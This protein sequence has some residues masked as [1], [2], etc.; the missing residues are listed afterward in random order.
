MRRA[1]HRQLEFAFADSPQGGKDARPTDAS[2]GKAYLLHIANPRKANP[3]AATAA[4][5][6]RLLEE[7]ASEPNLARALLHVASNKGAPGVDGKSVDAVLGSAR[8]LLPLL[9]RELL[10]G[11]YRPGDVR[12]VWIRK[13]QGG[14]RGLGIP[15]VMDRWAQQALLQVLEPIFEPG[16]HPSSHGFRPGRGASTAIAEA[17]SYVEQGLTWVVDLDL[18]KFFDRVNHQRL[19]AR[20]EC[21]VKDRRV[22]DLVR[23]MLKANVVMPDGTRVATQVGTPQG[24]PLSPLLSNIVLD[25]LDRELERRGLRFV[26]YADDCNIFVRSERAGRRVMDSTRRFIEGRMRLV[27]NEEKSKV[28]RPEASHFLGFRLCVGKAKAVEVRLSQRSH[29]RLGQRIRE[30]TPRLLGRSLTDCFENANRYLRGW[31]AHFRICTVEELWYFDRYDAHLRRRIRATIVR[32]HKRPRFLHRH[33]CRRGA[34]SRAATRAA[35]SRR[36]PWWQA[37]HPA[38]K[39]A[40]PNAWFAER[41]VSLR[42]EWRRLNPAPKP[43]SGQLL[44]FAP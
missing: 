1:R 2:A 23:R 11:R 27:V 3:L 19:L 29:D 16:L 38:L 20:L 31:M 8:R 5:T 33:L 25:E 17:K 28:T 40:Y 9:H 44:L 15:N 39:T 12:R 42:E 4:G 36:G 34:G 37:N 35:Y 24:G 22:L 21:R 10:S 14:L 6:E 13:P 32:Q 7:A 43:A 26:R 41:L 30:L 18:S